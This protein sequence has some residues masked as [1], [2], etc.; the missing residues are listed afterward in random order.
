MVVRTIVNVGELGP[1]EV[2]WPEDETYTMDE[3]VNLELV[4]DDLQVWSA[5]VD[6]PDCDPTGCGC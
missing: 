3:F 2:R 5:D 6:D 1:N 4:V